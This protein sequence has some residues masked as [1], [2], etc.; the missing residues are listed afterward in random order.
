MRKNV[1]L[2]TCAVIA[3]MFLALPYSA[4]G[5]SNPDTVNDAPYRG[6]LE[7]DPEYV[8]GT[9]N[10]LKTNEDCPLSINLRDYFQPGWVS[11]SL[12][13]TENILCE[14]GG[15]VRDVVKITPNADWHGVENFFV[16][17]WYYVGIEGIQ[18]PVVEF[19]SLEVLA[20]NDA[21]MSARLLPIAL[22][23]D[24]TFYDFD[25]SN[26]F[27]DI[28]SELVYGVDQILYTKH[29]MYSKLKR[30]MQTQL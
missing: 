25:I 20:V 19:F 10:Y 14:M 21:P 24:G 13:K 23:E 26:Y 28:D 18:Y 3:V 5:Y 4:I 30:I 8:D 1:N 22:D 6:G 12:P 16:S 15:F 17:A 29:R 11:I 2:I 9:I 7:Y 27:S